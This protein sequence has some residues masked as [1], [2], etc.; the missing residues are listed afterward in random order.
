MV[1]AYI[2]LNRPDGILYGCRF[3]VLF[4]ERYDNVYVDDYDIGQNPKMNYIYNECSTYPYIITY[5]DANANVTEYCCGDDDDLFAN[6]NGRLIYTCFLLYNSHTIKVNT[7]SHILNGSTINQQIGN[8]I[9]NILDGK[10]INNDGS[11]NEE[12]TTKFQN[13]LLNSDSSEYLHDTMYI[14]VV[15]LSKSQIIG[16]SNIYTNIR[17]GEV[18][19]DNF[20]SLKFKELD[21][22]TMEVTDIISND[23]NQNLI[24]ES[25]RYEEGYYL[26][27]DSSS[28]FKYNSGDPDRYVPK[29]N[30]R[31]KVPVEPGDYYIYTNSYFGAFVKDT[32]GKFICISKPNIQ[33][34]G[35]MPIEYVTFPIEIYLNKDLYHEENGSIP[36]YLVKFKGVGIESDIFKTNLIN[37][38][39]D[40][41]KTY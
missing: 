2:T 8:K 33:F 13:I 9:Y 24:I 17:I 22:N 7:L 11:I 27:L 35:S 29:F 23:E 41:I 18:N 5:P 20:L 4:N 36:I 31:W 30:L 1:N 34:M 16:D 6:S 28:T 14:S 25:D 39:T 12:D 38:V 15:T 37:G 10:I 26:N 19:G 32:G 21:G 3:G 40:F